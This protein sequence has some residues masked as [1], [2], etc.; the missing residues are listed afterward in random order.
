MP[1]ESTVRH[2]VEQYWKRF[3]S[4]DV[5]GLVA[6][7]TDDATVEDPVGTPVRHGIAEIRAFYESAQALADSIEL[8]SLGVTEV[9]G[10]Q[11]AF[12]MEI[13]P[14]IAGTTY[15]LH[16][17]DVMTFTDDGRITSMRAFC[18][19]EKLRPAD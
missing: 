15:L 10:D 16:A 7:Y 9:C 12:A 19:Q 4:G 2:T 13:R 17:I 11:A 18:Q 1:D 6:L 5:D 3:S 14:V 8:R